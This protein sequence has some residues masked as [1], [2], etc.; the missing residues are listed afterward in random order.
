MPIFS[1]GF[2][3]L[4]FFK[5]RDFSP[6]HSNQFWFSSS[7]FSFQVGRFFCPE[8]Y[9]YGSLSQ[10]STGLEGFF[11]R[12]AKLSNALRSAEFASKKK[13]N[14]NDVLYLNILLKHPT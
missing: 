10:F 5:L 9:I 4:S 8:F 1:T 14:C 7:N 3:L 12:I 11:I 13:S 2:S 6:G